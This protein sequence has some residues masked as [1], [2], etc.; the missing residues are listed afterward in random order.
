M[1]L[2]VPP[3]GGVDRAGGLVPDRAPAGKAEA[4]KDFSKV[5]EDS[6]QV[7]T[8]PAS[9]P[10]ELRDEVERASARYDELHRQG[11]ELHFATEPDSGRV[12]VEVRDLDG[13]VLRTLQPSEAL[14]VISGAP[15]EDR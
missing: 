12:T 2:N 4:T 9:P 3:T 14:E 7:D 1:D 13:E 8:V 11:R 10:P 5:L 15:L 6:V